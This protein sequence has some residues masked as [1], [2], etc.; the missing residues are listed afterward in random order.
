MTYITKG[1][2]IILHVRRQTMPPFTVKFC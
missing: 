1:V 2:A